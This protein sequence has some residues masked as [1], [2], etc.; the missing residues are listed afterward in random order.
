MCLLVCQT[1]SRQCPGLL[2]FCLHPTSAAVTACQYCRKEGGCANPH[3]L[4]MI[5]HCGLWLH[6]THPLPVVDIGQVCTPPLS[7]SL[8]PSQLLIYPPTAQFDELRRYTAHQAQLAHTGP[9]SPQSMHAR[10]HACTHTQ[11]ARA[12]LHH[13]C[14]FCSF[15]ALPTLYAYCKEAYHPP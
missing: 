2:H 4:V 8:P 9:P 1:R 12:Q 6:S 15:K 7:G 10:A 13:M 11:T 5:T 14:R 3:G